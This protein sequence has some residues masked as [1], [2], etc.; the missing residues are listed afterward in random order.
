MAHLSALFVLARHSEVVILV[1]VLV[2]LKR[3]YAHQLMEGGCCE[4]MVRFQGS[5][6]RGGNKRSFREQ[7]R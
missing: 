4:A 2:A 5:Q 1:R 3:A 7:P 6:Q